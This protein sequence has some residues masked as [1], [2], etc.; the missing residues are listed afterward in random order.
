MYSAVLQINSITT[1]PLDLYITECLC[2][3]L[4]NLSMKRFASH[5]LL[6][7]KINAAV[8]IQWYLDSVTHHL[9]VLI[10]VSIFNGHKLVT[11]Q[12]Q[13]GNSLS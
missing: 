13:Q 12:F 8:L 4:H 7:T 11:V 3:D 10:L 9:L 1:F 6:F 2:P 5:A